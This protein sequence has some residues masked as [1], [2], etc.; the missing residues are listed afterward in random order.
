MFMY[1]TRWTVLKHGTK[2]NDVYNTE[3]N[4]M[5]FFFDNYVF[6]L[7]ACTIN[8]TCTPHGSH[9]YQRLETQ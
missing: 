1:C 3:R 4:S 7:Y 9:Q 5:I 2:Q 8:Y 6:T